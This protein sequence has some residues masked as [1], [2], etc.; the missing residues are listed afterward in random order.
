[1]PAA[2]KASTSRRT[3]DF[4]IFFTGQSVSNLGTSVTLFALP[5]LVYNLTGSALNLA[6]T[7][8]SEFVPYLLFGLIIGAWVDRVNRKRLMIFTDLTRAYVIASIPVAARLGILT[9]GWIYIVGFLAS[10]LAIVFNSCEFA[11]IPSLAG[12]DDL[13]TANGRIQASYST[14]SVLGPIVAGALVAALPVASFMAFDAISFF[15]SAITLILIRASFNTAPGEP[16]RTHILRDI[17]DGLRY[18]LRHPVLRNI[19]AMMALVNFFGT[20]VYTQ[21]VVFAKVRLGADNAQVA[22]L[23]AAGSAGVVV[24]SLLAGLLRKHWT[25]SRVALGALMLEGVITA[26]MATQHAYWIALPLWALASGLGILFN[27]NTGSLRQAIVPNELLGRVISIAGVLAWSAIPLGAFLGGF[28]I[29]QT[30]NVALVYFAI[31]VITFL[32]PLVFSFTALGHAERYLPTPAAPA[33][34][35]EAQ[36]APVHT[37]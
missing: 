25:F 30:G 26:I 32:I 16:K 22:W 10:T 21:L 34:T 29:Q 13:V 4:W 31:G 23:F 36:R 14:M 11:A 5:L 27:I 1:M 7:T 18:V 15:L 35:P 17:A 28:A 12:Q 33:E 9:V 20:T 2:T 37:A 19:S 6:F 8:V 24:L 3:R